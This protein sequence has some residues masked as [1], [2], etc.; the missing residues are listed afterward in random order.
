MG[1]L[2]DLDYRLRQVKLGQNP[3]ATNNFSFGADLPDISQLPLNYYFKPT[4]VNPEDVEDKTK[5]TNKTPFNWN[6]AAQ[7]GLTAANFFTQK[8]ENPSWW[9]TGVTYGKQMPGIGGAIF[10][11]IDTLNNLGGHENTSK[12]NIDENL[13]STQAAEYGGAYDYMRDV[14]DQT[15]K[16]VG[17][18][19][20]IG[21]NTKKKKRKAKLL[22][23]QI[24][25]Q[26]NERRDYEALASNPYSGLQ[27]ATN[28]INATQPLPIG[29]KHG[30][31]I[32]YVEKI[33]PYVEEI[34]VEDITS[35]QKGGSFNILPEGALH[36]RKHNIDLD[37]I[38]KK[39]IPVIS[40]KE[41][42]TVEQQA[43]IE[44]D[45]IILR[46]QVTEDIEKA[47]K[48]YKETN[49]ETIPIEI[50][51]MLVNEILYN[52]KDNLNLLNK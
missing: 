11:G 26:E 12:W 33:I 10:T 40:E 25:A 41:D 23:G 15:G 37:N 1:F 38:T 31:S 2:D 52:T 45:E 24:A 22:E 4:E 44:R 30:G 21:D 29:F 6:G 27:R 18:F 49:D 48:K 51:K 34:I 19:T 46:L 3:Y 7:F 50:G 39:G 28:V 32:S 47:Q 17:L 5:K 43:E 36:A 8:V 42:G 14:S 16:R 13:A 35:F 20:G 9:N